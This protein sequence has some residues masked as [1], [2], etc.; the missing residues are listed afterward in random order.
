M[1]TPT[2]RI[3]LGETISKPPDI[4]EPTP[5]LTLDY[6]FDEGRG[7]WLNIIRLLAIL[8]IIYGTTSGLISGFAAAYNF[9]SQARAGLLRAGRAFG[10]DILI[11]ALSLSTLANLLLVFAA[12]G[13]LARV[14]FCRSL[15][16]FSCGLEVSMS[17]AR[18]ILS[19][20][21]PMRPNVLLIGLNTLP[22]VINSVMFPLAVAVILSRR[23]VKQ[24][25][26]LH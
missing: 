12:A 1:G 13:C 23:P 8:C 14:R 7:E 21:I 15:I 4:V 19:F 25:F 20:I 10:I 3:F 5:V 2:T 9:S 18:W 17:L 11:A 24:A 16:V 26:A 6:Q 22:Q